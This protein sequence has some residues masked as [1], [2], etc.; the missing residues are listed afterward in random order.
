LACDFRIAAEGTLFYFPEVELASPLDWQGV[1]RMA[2]EIGLARAR[3]MVMLSE[4]VDAAR[5]E[6]FGLLNRVVPADQ[7]DDA[8]S[9]WAKRVVDQPEISVHMTKT[10]F[11]AYS[12]T[13]PV[14]DATLFE[15]ALLLEALNDDQAKANFGVIAPRTEGQ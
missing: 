10:Q 5:A 9:A 12:A 4:R 3:E 6:R 14:G 8:V 11:R 13:I 1:P 2:R 7:L 15:P